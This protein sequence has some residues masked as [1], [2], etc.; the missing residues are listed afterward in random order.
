MESAA[1]DEMKE[2]IQRTHVVWRLQASLLIRPSKKQLEAFYLFIYSTHLE[3]GVPFVHLLTL[4]RLQFP[5]VIR[6]IKVPA[7][8]WADLVQVGMGE[9]NMWGMLVH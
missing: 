5:Q 3:P 4:A 8:R 9:E 6:N 2:I 1:A 7:C